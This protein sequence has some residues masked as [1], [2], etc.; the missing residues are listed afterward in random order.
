MLY[1][2]TSAEYDLKMYQEEMGLVRQALELKRNEQILAML[3]QQGRIQAK[4]Q[5]QQALGMS[6]FNQLVSGLKIGAEI[7]DYS[8]K[9]A[10]E[11]I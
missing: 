1:L 11:E 3:E 6:E 10:E 7:N 2:E 9:L 8:K 4:Q 5:Q